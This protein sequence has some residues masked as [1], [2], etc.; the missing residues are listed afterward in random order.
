MNARTVLL[1]LLLPLQAA[2]QGYAGLGTAA[3]GY[4]P[5]TPPA[6]IAFP[7]DHGAHPGFRVEWWYLTANLTGADGAEYGAQWTLFRIALAPEDGPDAEADGWANPVIWMGHAA[8]TSA[9]R[10]AFAETFAR[11]GIG[12]AGVALGP[13]RAW[14]DDWEIAGADALADI[15]V[16]ADGDGFGY[17]L[18]AVA[19]GPPVR[20]GDDGYSRKSAGGQASYYYSQPFYRVKGSDR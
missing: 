14:I 8:V 4:R 5:V 9:E 19:D 20:Q 1:L 18:R 17:R 13:F 16:T 7:R 12:Q 10:H 6:A 15:T 11:G 2:A 3:D